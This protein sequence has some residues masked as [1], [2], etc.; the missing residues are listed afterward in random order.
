MSIFDELYRGYR[1]AHK[2]SIDA[3]IGVRDANRS[4]RL[5]AADVLLLCAE[6]E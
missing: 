3:N 4:C 2:M 1:L 5:H 6:A